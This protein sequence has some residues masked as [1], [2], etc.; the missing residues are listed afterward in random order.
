MKKTEETTKHYE[1]GFLK[2]A[3]Q[4]AFREFNESGRV[5]GMKLLLTYEATGEPGCRIFFSETPVIDYDY[6]QYAMVHASTNVPCRTFELESMVIDEGF[7]ILASVTV[8]AMVRRGITRVQFVYRKDDVTEYATYDV[9]R[10][11]MYVDAEGVLQHADT[12]IFTEWE[13]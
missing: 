2:K 4:I 10:N 5:T 11:P 6:P 3:R 7:R 9:A 12:F 1:G 8:K 13:D